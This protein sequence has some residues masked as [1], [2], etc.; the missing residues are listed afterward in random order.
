MTQPP[1]AELAPAELL[2]KY[3]VLRLG[4]LRAP[5]QVFRALLAHHNFRR[6][7]DHN[8]ENGGTTECLD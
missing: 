5:D 1:G 7:S 4:A 6:L 3:I 2:A 8:S